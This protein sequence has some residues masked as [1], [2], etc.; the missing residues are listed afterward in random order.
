MLRDLPAHRCAQQSC[1]G[2]TGASTTGP[3]CR[4]ANTVQRFAHRGTHLRGTAI[5]ETETLL[6][7][8]RRRSC[9][10]AG[11]SLMRDRGLRHA[12]G[13]AAHVEP[14]AAIVPR[15]PARY[16][17]RRRRTC[18]ARGFIHRSMQSPPL[19]KEHASYTAR[20]RVE[21][22]KN[23]R[24]TGA[25]GGAGINSTA[26][27]AAYFCATKSAA[28]CSELTSRRWRGG[29]RESE[30]VFRGRSRGRRTWGGLEDS[31]S[32]GWLRSPTKAT[33]RPRDRLRHGSPSSRPRET[34]V[35]STTAPVTDADF[36]DASACAAASMNCLSHRKGVL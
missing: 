5:N 20:L 33:P 29:R 34:A 3:T 7:C 14:R 21:T 13:A 17:R 28:C 32:Q 2:W 9:T 24:A 27:R 19:Q 18:G 25:T 31:S 12:C 6:R 26:A 1:W 36:S 8:D 23:A 4:A 30:S 15:T 11:S 10:A 22:H 35:S 16:N